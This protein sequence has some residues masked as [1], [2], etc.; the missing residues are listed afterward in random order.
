MSGCHYDGLSS[1]SPEDRD[2]CIMIVSSHVNYS[3]IHEYEKISLNR[4]N[5]PFIGKY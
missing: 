5:M 2:I 3:T 1:V 4:N